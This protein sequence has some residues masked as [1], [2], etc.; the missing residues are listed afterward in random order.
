M[1]VQQGEVGYWFLDVVT[2]FHIEIVNNL[3]KRHLHLI[4]VWANKLPLCLKITSLFNLIAVRPDCISMNAC[5]EILVYIPSKWSKIYNVKSN[6]QLNVNCMISQLFI[7]MESAITSSHIV[8]RLIA[9]LAHC[10]QY[11][12]NIKIYCQCTLLYTQLYT[13]ICPTTAGGF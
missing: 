7:S 13:I 8:F 5:K 10:N 1:V 4:R 11:R 2:S 6:F 9:A 12:K 3:K